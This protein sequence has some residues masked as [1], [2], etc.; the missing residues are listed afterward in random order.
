MTGEQDVSKTA[1]APHTLRGN[2]HSIG[3]SIWP[4]G[5]GPWCEV[6]TAQVHALLPEESVLVRGARPR[7]EWKIR[8]RPGALNVGRKP[9]VSMGE[10]VGDVRD[11]VRLSRGDRSLPLPITWVRPSGG[12]WAA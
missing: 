12:R 1:R 3:A 6:A 11:I 10:Y 7:L 2:T 4:G 8:Q 9:G 5:R